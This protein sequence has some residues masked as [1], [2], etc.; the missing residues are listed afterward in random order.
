[1]AAKRCISSCD[2]ILVIGAGA[3]GVTGEDK[4]AGDVRLSPTFHANK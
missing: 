1:M 2:T 3:E 4:R